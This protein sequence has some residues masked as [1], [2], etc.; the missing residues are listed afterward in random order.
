MARLF[1]LVAAV[2]AVAASFAASASALTC[3]TTPLVDRL[4]ESDGAFVG[5]LL[6]V[7][8]APSIGGVERRIFRYK[9]KVEVK[10]DLGATVDVLTQTGSRGLQQVYGEDAGILMNRVGGAWVSTICG[11]TSPAALLATADEPRGT[12]AKVA[13]GLVI[14][15]LV[16]LF[17]V[18]RLRR[19]TRPYLPGAPLP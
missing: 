6:S 7:R 9:V 14:L 11:Q 4:A 5:P 3:S 18:R 2:C 16:L 17:A 8:R 12:F 1:T 19:G 15:G 10:G 13:I